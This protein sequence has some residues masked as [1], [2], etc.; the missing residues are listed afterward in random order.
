MIDTLYIFQAITGVDDIAVALAT[1]E[2]N[3]WDINVSSS[4]LYFLFY[5]TLKF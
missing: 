4:P 2:Q 1:L 3:N 5:L